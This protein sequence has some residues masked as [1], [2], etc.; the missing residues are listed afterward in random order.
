MFSVP[1]LRHI[2]QSH[3]TCPTCSRKQMWRVSE[4]E[5]D[6][7][8]SLGA[9]LFGRISALA[10][11][12]DL[13]EPL[14]RIQGVAPLLSKHICPCMTGLLM[15]TKPGILL[16]CIPLQGCHLVTV[17]KVCFMPLQLFFIFAQAWTHSAFKTMKQNGA[18]SDT[19]VAR[20]S[21]GFTWCSRM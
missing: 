8:S 13:W 21:C 15:D 12:T 17:T 4:P 9:W 19:V 10:G 7:D 5:G 11:G 16:G 6:R 3:R 1:D 18:V 20:N 14:S 2:V